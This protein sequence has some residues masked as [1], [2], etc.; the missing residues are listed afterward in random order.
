MLPD[1]DGIAT[2]WLD[3]P[4]ALLAH[5]G[6]THSVLF[7]FLF[8][9]LS[10]VA[11]NFF[12]RERTF[13][14][15]TVFLFVLLEMF[16]HIFMDGFNAYGTAWFEPFSHYRVAFHALYLTDPLFTAWP[17]IALIFLIIHWNK[18]AY[19]LQNIA[20]KGILLSAAYLFLSLLFKESVEAAVRRTLRADKITAVDFTTT[21][22]PFNSMLWYVMVRN[23]K[24]YYIGYRS[25]WDGSAGI[26]WKY[27]P[28]Q[29]EL[30][31][32]AADKEELDQLLRFAAGYH[33]FSRSG[34]TVHVNVLR[35]GQACGWHDANAPFVFRYPLNKE[36]SRT[37]LQ[38][39]RLEGWS[40]P[41]VRSLFYQMFGMRHARLK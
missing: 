31:V 38:E 10:S 34:D 39:G 23:G 41:S 9:F 32:Y 20:R 33:T 16:L 40:G 30:E 27:H 12:L 29:K 36:S 4:S 17:V 13:S 5:R 2:A 8:A 1:I 7:V 21:P 11:Y 26:R 3:H 24:G 6:F 25:V 15:R 14:Q 28:L 22:T 19:D 18:K 37:Q 35:F